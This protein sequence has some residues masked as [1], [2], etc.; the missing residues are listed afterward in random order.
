MKKLTEKQKL[1]TYRNV[2][3]ALNVKLRKVDKSM[4]IS[5]YGI[6]ICNELE[7]LHKKLNTCSPK[8]NPENNMVVNYPEIA[9]RKPKDKNFGDSWWFFNRAGILKRIS[10]V[11]TAIAEVLRN[12][13]DLV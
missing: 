5:F 8:Q 7:S 6:F 13:P 9:K 3:K 4:S 12:N 2:L 11:E 10:V 1:S